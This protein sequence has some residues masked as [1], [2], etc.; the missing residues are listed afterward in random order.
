[1]I[2]TS[3]LLKNA[4][5]FL[6]QKVRRNQREKKLK[7]VNKVQKDALRFQEKILFGSVLNLG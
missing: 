2:L 1:M 3:E 6:C 4:S 5:V 7:S